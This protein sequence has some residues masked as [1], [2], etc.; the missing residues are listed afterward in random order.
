MTFVWLLSI[1]FFD[2]SSPRND[3]FKI[4]W[5]PSFWW[6]REAWYLYAWPWQLNTAT[7]HLN[8]LKTS[9]FQN[10]D[11]PW[12]SNHNDNAR[13]C[14]HFISKNEHRKTFEG[15]EY[16]VFKKVPTN[17]H[18]K[19]LTKQIVPYLLHGFIWFKM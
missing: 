15:N 19:L 16:S 4:L 14:E 5:H 7:I 9:W 6:P 3:Y 10:S 8:D 11:L 17:T 2:L 12:M 13:I 18:F 1:N